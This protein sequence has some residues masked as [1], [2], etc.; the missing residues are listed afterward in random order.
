MGYS[1]APAVSHAI[2]WGKKHEETAR[3]MYIVEQRRKQHPSLTV[4][5]SGLNIFS[6]AP[7]LAA[8][9]DGKVHDPT[10][11]PAD[12]VLEIKCPYSIDGVNVTDLLPTEIAS[13]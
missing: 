7:F 4:K 10:A 13:R 1:S 3:K 9:T 11:R 6:P 5:P 2:T 12:G 8:S